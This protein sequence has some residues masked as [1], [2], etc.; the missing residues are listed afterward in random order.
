MFFVRECSDNACQLLSIFFFSKSFPFCFE[1]SRSKSSFIK[2]TSQKKKHEPDSSTPS[3]ENLLGHI[4]NSYDFVWNSNAPF[5][6]EDNK[7]SIIYG[8]L[9]V[10]PPPSGNTSQPLN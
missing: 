5:P 2:K 1:T 10:S 4:K 9:V 8:E 6:L 7:D 3:S